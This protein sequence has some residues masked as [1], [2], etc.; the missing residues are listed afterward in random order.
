MDW[1]QTLDPTARLA[2]AAGWIRAID[3]DWFAIGL[4]VVLG[5]AVLF[6]LLALGLFWFSGPLRRQRPV[7]M[8][9]LTEGYRMVQG[10]AMAPLLR[11]PCSGRP[12]VWWQIRTWEAE[13]VRQRS[14]EADG[15]QA[16]GWDV[17]WAERR[18]ETS[19]PAIECREGLLGCALQP[20]GIGLAVPSEVRVWEGPQAEPQA[21]DVPARAGDVL[22]RYEHRVHGYRIHGDRLLR[23]NRFRHAEEI[24]LPGSARFVVGQVERAAA[25][26][27]AGAPQWRIGPVAGGSLRQPYVVSAQ[28]LA[29]VQGRIG[30][31]WRGAA[32]ICGVLLAIGGFMF[33]ARPG[34]G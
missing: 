21:C 23:D 19:T 14:G 34:S 17:I 13:L 10:Q 7:A 29:Q 18:R 1:L 24:I 11:A 8:A 6:G 26:L 4:A 20:N 2:A 12:C 32:V 3:D 27:A 16:G 28:P 9:A 25:P 30:R 22:R 15:R 5:L 33:W 31:A